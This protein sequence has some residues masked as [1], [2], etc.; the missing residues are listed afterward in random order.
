MRTI[1]S[2]YLGLLAATA[3]ASPLERRQSTTAV[4]NFGNNTGTPQHLASGTL[5]GLPDV[6]SQIPDNFF[7]D[8]GW[9]YERAGGAQTSGKG[10]IAG[11]AAYKSVV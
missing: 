8:I 10:W 2:S 6:V 9:N 7:S 5:Y 11:L 4:V 3:V 1:V